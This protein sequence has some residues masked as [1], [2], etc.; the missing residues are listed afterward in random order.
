LPLIQ[1]IKFLP[2]KGAGA[3]YIELYSGAGRS[4][5]K[6]T[7]TIIDGSPLVAYKAASDSGARFSDLYLA[8]LDARNS[9]AVAQHINARGGAANSYV[10][11]ADVTVDGSTLNKR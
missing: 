5:V 7:N 3:S 9:D 2:P 10:G 8:D 4:L 11:S 1:R 6:N